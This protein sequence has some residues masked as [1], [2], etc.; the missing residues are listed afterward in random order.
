M[1]HYV[2]LSV[3]FTLG[4]DHDSEFSDVHLSYV[5]CQWQNDN[6]EVCDLDVLVLKDRC[7]KAFDGDIESREIVY[8][9]LCRYLLQSF[10]PSI[11]S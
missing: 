11:I 2:Y 9:T 10:N 6:N 4:K 3:L 8:G 7:A 1:K 5:N